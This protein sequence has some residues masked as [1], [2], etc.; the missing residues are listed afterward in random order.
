MEI[1]LATSNEH[2]LK[3]VEVILAPFNIQIVGLQSL[4]DVY[5]E[6]V[7]DSDTFEG[8]AKLK[9]VG[10]AYSTGRRC[11]ADDSG[12]VVDAIEG[13]PGVLSARFAGVDGSREERDAANN[14]LLLSLMKDVPEEERSARFVCAICVA[15]PDGTIFA[16]SMG[17]LEGTI[18]SSPKGNNGFGYDPLLYVARVNKTSAEMTPEEKNLLSHRGEAVRNIVNNFVQ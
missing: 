12:L 8:N 4:S 11:M 17:T 6:P 3:E 16:Q 18:A 5:E 14:A 1:L 13:K 15:D 9:A 2:K 7:E 10:Y